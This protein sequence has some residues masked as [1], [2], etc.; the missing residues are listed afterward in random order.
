MPTSPATTA[1]RLRPRGLILALIPGGF[2]AVIGFAA[3]FDSISP[4]SQTEAGIENS[5]AL[6]AL[7]FATFLLIIGTVIWLMQPHRCGNCREKLPH[8]ATTCATC[9]AELI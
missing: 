4:N 9:G 1:H 5:L 6:A 8:R 2:V 3:L 7:M